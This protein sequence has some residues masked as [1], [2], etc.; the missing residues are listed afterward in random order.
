MRIA[1]V[2]DLLHPYSK[3]GVEKRVAD[4][5]RGLALRGHE[6]HLFGV[7]G[8]DGPDRIVRAGVCLHGIRAP[9][10]LHD[11]SGRRSVWQAA[12]VAYRLAWSLRGQRF[13]VVDVQSAS[14]L[15]GLV[16]LL[17]CRLSGTPSVLT[18]H[19][20]WGPYWRVY[21]GRLA[22]LGM[23]IERL[24]ALMA[25]RHVAVSGRTA[26][27]LRWLKVSDVEV[28]PAGLDMEEMA[29]VEADTRA[30]D[31]LYVGRLDR[32]K[33]VDLLLEA[34]RLLACRGFRPR[35]GIVGDGPCRRRLEAMSHEPLDVT[36]LGRLESDREVWALLKS[37]RLFVSSSVREGFGLAVLEALACGVPVL[38]AEDPDNAAQDLVTPGVNGLTVKPDPDQLAAAIRLLLEDEKARRQLASHARTS[39]R[40]YRSSRSVTLMEAI[41]IGEGQDAPGGASFAAEIPQPEAT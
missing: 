2:Y 3:G 1:F 22:P 18:W 26:A 12:R 33:N 13:D 16:A 29:A 24:L 9:S 11:R 34:V 32:H 30:H 25:D 28:V 31:V 38:V 23:T 5:A 27:R 15:T 40:G 20:V 10:R 17:W 21:L 6:V 19:E 14:P 8:W 4:L 36:F 37:A 7:K 35:V 41:Y 39:V